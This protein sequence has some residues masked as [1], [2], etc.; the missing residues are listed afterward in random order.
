MNYDETIIR[1][2]SEAGSDGLSIRKIVRHVYNSNNSFFESA[3]IN[4]I[5]S[6]VV[7]FL[8]D[9]SRKSFFGN[10]LIEPVGRRGVFRINKKSIFYNQY[11][12][13]DI[14][15]EQD[16]APSIV[17]SLNLFDD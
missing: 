16:G 8:H 6:Y 1:V 9:H 2:L 15:D 17:N 11:C 5:H 10:A 13:H 3:D 7:K 12:H 4:E 14:E